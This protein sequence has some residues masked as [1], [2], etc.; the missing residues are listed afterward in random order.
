MFSKDVIETDDFIDNLTLSAQALYMHLCMGADDDGFVD[1][2]NRIRKSIESS[3][4]DFDLLME[5]GY[6][7][8]FPNGT[9]VISH[10]RT[11]NYIRK[12]RYKAT[13]HQTE[14]SQLGF[15]DGRYVLKECSASV[16]NPTISNNS[17]NNGVQKFEEFWKAYPRK[18]H[19]SLAESQYAMEVMHGISE[20]MLI[21]SA[22]KY[23]SEK[24]GSEKQFI[25]CPDTWLKDALYADYEAKDGEMDKPLS[26]KPKSAYAEGDE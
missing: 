6:L 16:Q 23:A 12:D 8:K 5:K 7:L 21:A 18:E 1:S 25:R 11:N 26:A 24:A 20:D 14:L 19:K 17:F 3:Q 9:I 4:S 22:K 10:W 15:I 13:M 2:A